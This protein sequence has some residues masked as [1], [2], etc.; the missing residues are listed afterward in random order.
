MLKECRLAVRRLTVLLLLDFSLHL[1][2]SSQEAQRQRHHSSSCV[3]RMSNQSIFFFQSVTLEHL[4]TVT[5]MLV[6]LA[7]YGFMK[8]N[9]TINFFALYCCQKKRSDT[10][11]F[12]VF[13]TWVSNSLLYFIFFELFKHK[14]ETVFAVDKDNMSLTKHFYRLK[15]VV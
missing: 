11:P 1:H 10:F 3:I 2:G 8:K 6:S 7:V 12:F 5:E 13:Y 14:Q 15:G 4:P 9:L